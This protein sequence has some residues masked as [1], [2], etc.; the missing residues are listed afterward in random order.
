MRSADALSFFV[1]LA[2]PVTPIT[3]FSTATALRWAKVGDLSALQ[4]DRDA[5]KARVAVVFPE[6]KPAAIPQS[7]GQLFRFVH[8]I[9]AGN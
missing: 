6:K 1:T 7:A 4:P 3:Y 8:E 2:E 5:F 9:N